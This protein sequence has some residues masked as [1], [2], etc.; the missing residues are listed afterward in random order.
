V[1]VNP[2]QARQLLAAVTYV[3]A[4]RQHDNDRGRRLYAFFASL[5]YAGLRPGE[6]LQ[7]ARA[8]LILPEDGW[9]E[10]R[11]A[12]S[13]PEV[14]GAHFADSTERRRPLKRRRPEDVRFV[15]LP[16]DLV[17]IL[18]SHLDE[19]DTAPDGRLFP[20]RRTGRG[21]PSSVYTRIWQDARTTALGAE[22]AATS[23]ARRPYDLRHAALSSWLNAGV[24]APEVAE[25]AG[26]SV[27]V[28]LQVYAKCLHG[29]RATFN[30][31]IETLLSE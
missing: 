11:L 13:L 18:H 30:A 15:P 7:L 19:F 2:A 8:D 23:L 22:G 17:R 24:P 10:A 14:S 12:A 9:G 25:R 20:A 1:V 29:Q 6:A 3:R 27:A 21:V 26:H 31:R 28:L 4:T 5:Y 16:P